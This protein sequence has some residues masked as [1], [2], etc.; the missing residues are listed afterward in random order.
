MK[1]EKEVK[2][3]AEKEEEKMENVEDQEAKNS[4][5]QNHH[6]NV[7]IGTLM[8]QMSLFAGSREKLVSAF[9]L[10]EPEEL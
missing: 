3:T 5:I 9:S 7:N 10:L 4:V 1:S 6:S 2:G 8:S